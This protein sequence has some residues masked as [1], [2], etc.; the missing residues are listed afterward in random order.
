[1]LVICLLSVGLARLSLSLSGFFLQM[2]STEFI[3]GHNPV[4]DFDVNQAGVSVCPKSEAIRWVL[5]TYFIKCWSCAPLSQLFKRSAF[6]YRYLSVNK[7]DGTI[8]AVIS[9]LVK[10]T[11]LCVHTSFNLVS[12]GQS[13]LV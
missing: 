8:P 11:L 9:T 5:A 6:I 12:V 7:L 13:I 3:G 10:L 2:A 4:T 1:M